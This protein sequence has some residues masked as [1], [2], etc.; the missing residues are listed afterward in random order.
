MGA[1]PDSAPI[2]IFFLKIGKIIEVEKNFFNSK[3]H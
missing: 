2:F 1:E 3:S